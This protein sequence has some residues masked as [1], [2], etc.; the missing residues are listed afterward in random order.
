MAKYLKRPDHAQ[1]GEHPPPRF[2]ESLKV[3]KKTISYETSLKKYI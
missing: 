1:K 2:L 3:G